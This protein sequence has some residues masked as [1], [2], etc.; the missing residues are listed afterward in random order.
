MTPRTLGHDVTFDVTALRAH[1]P[2]LESGMAFFDAPGGTQTPRAVGEAIASTITSPLTIP[3]GNAVQSEVNADNAES[4][5]RSAFGDFLN[6][7]ERGVVYG[8]SATQLNYDLSRAL[9]KAWGPE[10]EV[11]VSRL[12]HDS[13]VRP[14]IQAAESVG[15]TVRWI[16]FD[17]TTAEVSW[18][19]VEE[20]INANTRLVAVTAASNVLGTKPPVRKIADAAHAVG[21]HV[22][23]DAVHYA[24]HDLVDIPGLGADSLVCSPYKF[25]G[26]HM[27]VLGARVEVLDGLRP[28]KL[29]P[30]SDAVPHRFEL[31]TLPYEIMAGA[32]AAVDFLAEIAPGSAATRRDKLRAS[33]EAIEAHEASLRKQ[34][35]EGLTSLGEDVVVHSCA[36][37]RTPTT[38]ITLPGRK[39]WDAYE[40]LAT[41]DISAPADSSFYAYEAFRRLNLDDDNAMRFGLAPYVTEAEVSRLLNGLSDFLS[42]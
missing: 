27:A 38:L 15:T 16:D 22:H 8:R 25:L 20:A 1:F 28:D 11:V 34:L 10:D 40:F 37:Q 33:F 42:R 14:W 3:G 2:A 30:S 29:L 35:E 17:P 6:L 32:T 12:D 9:A 19:S 18:E 5:F 4:G 31:G 39:T 21:A 36:W 13:N 24:A 26:P 41:R 7:S 23:V